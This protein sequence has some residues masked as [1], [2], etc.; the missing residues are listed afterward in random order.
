MRAWWLPVCGLIA[1]VRS[2]AVTCADGTLC[3][4]GFSCVVGGGCAA[5]GP[6]GDGVINVGEE[7]DDGNHASHDGCSSGCLIE[8]PTWTDASDPAGP[9]ARRA[10]AAAWFPDRGVGVLHGG[11]LQTALSDTWLWDGHWTRAADGPDRTFHQMAYDGVSRM[12]QFGGTDASTTRHGE[13][14][15][16]DGAQW[17]QVA[18][19]GPAPRFNH[20]MARD[21]APGVVLWGGTTAG[22]VDSETW[23]WTGA[24][25]ERGPDQN[26]QQDT[27]FVYV[28]LDNTVLATG[29]TSLLLY[30]WNGAWMPRES[31]L[32]RSDHVQDYD[33]DR[34]T[35]LSFGGSIGSVFADATDE[36]NGTD[37]LRVVPAG[38]RPPGREHAAGF[39]DPIRHGFVVFGGNLN[40]NFLGDT[41]I[42]RW[43][44]ATPDDACDGVTDADGDGLAGCADPDCWARCQPHCPPGA[45][46]DLA[47]P[48]CGDGACNPALETAALCP[49]DC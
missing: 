24:V 10:S 37:W 39:F 31:S 46:C 34:R 19:S 32:V 15:A 16:W 26:M 21:V 7:C 12:I 30:V 9:S 35:V 41:W 23:R 14:L 2:Q 36:W 44:S 29:S 49:D 27:R 20:L 4:E 18:T 48:H 13:T 22:G 47:A 45:P 40:A 6:C 11:I 5:V 25:W 42:L 17:T 38:D 3:P 33:P 8:Q 28:P 1:C 43:D